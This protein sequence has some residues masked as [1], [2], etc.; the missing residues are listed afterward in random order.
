MRG[1]LTPR[2]PAYGG[3]QDSDRYPQRVRN[4]ATEELHGWFTG[5][6]ACGRASGATTIIIT[7]VATRMA[8]SIL[9]RHLKHTLPI[10]AEFARYASTRRAYALFY[11]G[12]NFAPHLQAF[13]ATP[14]R[15]ALG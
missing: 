5:D 4:A 7:F 9:S 1:F 6:N 14:C 8:L 10:P 11:A 13:T 2:V 12:G 3:G 15:R